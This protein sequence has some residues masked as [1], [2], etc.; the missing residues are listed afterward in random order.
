MTVTFD[1]PYY[2]AVLLLN[3]PLHGLFGVDA[4]VEQA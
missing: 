2:D 1:D 3:L 4:R